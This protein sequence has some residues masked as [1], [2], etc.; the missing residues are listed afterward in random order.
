MSGYALGMQVG[1]R[2]VCVNDTFEAWVH[3]YYDQLP[4]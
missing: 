3:E 4:G 1:Q 2:V